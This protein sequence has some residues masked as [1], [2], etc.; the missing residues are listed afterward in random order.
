MC[1]MTGFKSVINNFRQ[2]VAIFI[3][4][5][6]N[7]VK[8]KIVERPEDF[9]YSGINFIKKGLYEVVFPPDPVIL[10]LIQ[11]IKNV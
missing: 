11:K 7:P 2:K 8:A 4:I 9:E 1:F 3:Y 6:K 5:M 10:L